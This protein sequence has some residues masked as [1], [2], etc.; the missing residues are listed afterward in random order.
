MREVGERLGDLRPSARTRS[1]RGAPARRA[2]CGPRTSTRSVIAPRLACQTTPPVGSAVSIATRTGI[3]QAGLAQVPGAGDAAGLLVADEVQHDPAV[4][5]AGRGRAPPQRRRACSRGRPSCRRSRARRSCRSPCAAEL[6][7]R[8]ARARRRSA[9]GSRRSAYLRPTVP[10]TTQGSSSSRAGGSS[11]S[12]G[13]SPRPVIASRSTRPQRPSPRPGGFSLSIA[14][15][16]ESRAAISSARCS[17]H[18]RTPASRLSS[19]RRPA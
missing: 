9:R 11:I 3:D 15:S 10:R 14:T 5:R 6:R 4:V 12:S 18:P 8:L 16:S 17:S 1:R 13:D 19:T 7:P 2:P